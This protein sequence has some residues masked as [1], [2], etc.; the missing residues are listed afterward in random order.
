[1]HP[2]KNLNNTEMKKKKNL[3]QQKKKETLYFLKN[4]IFGNNHPNVFLVEQVNELEYSG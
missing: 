2:K 4:C 1:M 3:F